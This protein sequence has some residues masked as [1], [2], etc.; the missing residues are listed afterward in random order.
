LA[1]GAGRGE[2]KRESKE[3]SVDESSLLL[4]LPTRVKFQLRIQPFLDLPLESP[5]SASVRQQINP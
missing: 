5:A 3:L 1:I 2:V 4:F